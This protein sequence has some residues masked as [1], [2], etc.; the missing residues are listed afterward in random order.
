MRCHLLLDSDALFLAKVW[1]RLPHNLIISGLLDITGRKQLLLLL[2]LS[3]QAIAHAFCLISLG[4]GSDKFIGDY[5]RF[6]QECPGFVQQFHLDDD[7]QILSVQTPFIRELFN[8]VSHLT[9]SNN[10]TSDEAEDSFR[11][12]DEMIPSIFRHGMI[13]DAAHKFFHNG[14]LLH[15]CSYFESLHRWQPILV[16]WTG[17]QNRETYASHFQCL[18]TIIASQTSRDNPEIRLSTF[19]SIISSVVD[20]SDAQRAGFE[21]AYVRFI[22]STDYGHRLLMREW[23]FDHQYQFPSF[24]QHQAVARG[25]L[26]GCR[27]HWT[28]SVTRISNNHHVIP[29]VKNM[30]F[31]KLINELFFAPTVESF[32]DVME[33][34]QSTFLNTTDWLRWWS[35]TEHAALLFPVLWQSDAQK[36]LPGIYT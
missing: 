27:Q 12:K 36:Y 28:E 8:Q 19:Q 32:R 18:F 24:E 26:K 21:T 13:T 33:S 6:L 4:S 23:E 16:S 3:H 20:F 34:I 17:L 35:R 10:I 31:R 30:E 14:K 25:L 29:P 22:T 2:I 15:T 5:I 11:S 7:V 1:H 9:G